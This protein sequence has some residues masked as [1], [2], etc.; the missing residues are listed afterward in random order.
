MP[1]PPPMQFQT[2]QFARTPAMS[3][4]MSKAGN[5][6][7]PLAKAAGQA[8]RAPDAGP[9]P[10]M[11]GAAQEGPV[12]PVNGEIPLLPGTPGSA[13]AGP[14]APPQAPPG[15]G[16]ML[17]NLLPQGMQGLIQPPAPPMMPGAALFSQAGDPTRGGVY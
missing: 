1:A 12:A 6:M 5:A 13:A 11:P 8:Y 7:S 10:G 9:L 4:M 14:M 3:E 17:R 16:Q 15:I 2:L